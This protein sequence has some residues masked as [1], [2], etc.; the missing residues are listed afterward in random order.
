MIYHKL[1]LSNDLDR[2]MIEGNSKKTGQ[3]TSSDKRMFSFK[4]LA[5]KGNEQKLIDTLRRRHGD[6]L[7]LIQDESPGI[8]R[9]RN[10][11]LKRALPNLFSDDNLYSNRVREL[12]ARLKRLKLVK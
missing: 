2:V 1:N 5:L 6:I 10:S 9:K 3:I 11:M 7:P 4:D 12:R 8:M